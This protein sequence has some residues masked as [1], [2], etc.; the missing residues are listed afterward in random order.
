[1]PVVS[2]KDLTEPHQIALMTFIAKV[3]PVRGGQLRSITADSVILQPPYT[4]AG[5]DAAKGIKSN[6]DFTDLTGYTQHQL[7]TKWLTDRTTTCNEFCSKAG[8]AMGFVAKGKFDGVG[9]FDIA[10]YLTQN[11]R[12]H[13]WVRADSGAKPEC[14]DVF[15]IFEK[16]LDQNGVNR[17]HMGVS[18]FMD[19]AQW[20]TV[21][22]GQGGPGT[23]Y[24]AVERKQ[25]PW[26]E[27][28]VQGWVNMK[29][30]L[31]AEDKISPWLGGWWE[32]LQAPND[33]WY[34]YFSAGGKVEYTPIKP[35]VLSQ[36]PINASLT[37]SFRMKGMFGVEVCWN[38]SD[39]DETFVIFV[40]PPPK[41]RN[42]PPSRKYTMTGT[43]VGTS[44]KLTAKRLMIE[45]LL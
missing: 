6:Q 45:G 13:C 39:A 19:G 18:L 37:G 26:P 8:T 34:Y 31:F 32:V 21:E 23:G 1:M 22:S 25:R 29:A 27:A 15:R 10:D 40:P 33:V 38:S 7:L 28:G 44:R 3:P 41:D 36:P 43:V 12:G 14:G 20:Y 30:L 11:G 42:A 4:R 17:N 35:S 16:A 9:R 24:D 2:E 5:I